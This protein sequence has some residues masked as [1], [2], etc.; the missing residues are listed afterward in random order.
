M[1]AA[2]ARPRASVRRSPAAASQ[3]NTAEASM[4]S[5]DTEAMLMKP[6]LEASAE[7]NQHRK[8]GRNTKKNRRSRF[9]SGISQAKKPRI[10]IGNM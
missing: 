7:Q 2:A 8:P 3:M 1:Q 6:R 4:F 10:L 5:A 9:F